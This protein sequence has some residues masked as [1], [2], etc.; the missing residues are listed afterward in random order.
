MGSPEVERG[1]PVNSAWTFSGAQGCFECSST[2]IRRSSKNRFLSGCYSIG[3]C[4]L[5][6]FAGSKIILIERCASVGEEG[7]VDEGDRMLD[8]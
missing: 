6:K 2:I 7:F 1:E 3:K 8:S 5:Q 4:C